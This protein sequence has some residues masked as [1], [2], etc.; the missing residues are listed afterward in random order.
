ML[1][2]ACERYQNLSEEEKEKNDNMVANISQKMKKI[3]WF[4]K[5]RDIKWKKMVY[6]NYKKIC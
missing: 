4:S 3:N 6:Y 2:K 1:K 5:E